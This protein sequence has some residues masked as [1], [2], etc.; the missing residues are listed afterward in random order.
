M[1]SDEGLELFYWPNY[2]LKTTWEE[3]D[4]LGS[5]TGFGSLTSDVLYL[6]GK[7]VGA[8]A[9]E[10]DRHR[11]I[12][13]RRVVSLSDFKGWP[14]GQLHDDLLRFIPDIIKGIN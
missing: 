4:R 5:V 8:N 3:L 14:K 2:R 13:E 11:G 9:E 1:I 12:Q 10:I 6:R 7:S